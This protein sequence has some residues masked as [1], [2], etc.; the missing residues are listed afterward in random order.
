MAKGI[1]S[2]ATPNP[3]KGKAQN[4]PPP[5]AATKKKKITRQQYKPLDPVNAMV[6]V[7]ALDNPSKKE[8]PSPWISM[9]GVVESV[10]T[11]NPYFYKVKIE[12]N[13]GFQ[14]APFSIVCAEHH[15]EGRLTDYGSAEYEIE[16]I[17]DSRL[18]RHGIDE[19][20]CDKP[21]RATRDFLIKWVGW[22][23]VITW[24]PGPRLQPESI[25][26]YDETLKIKKKQSE[27]VR[28]VLIL[29]LSSVSSAT[30]LTQGNILNEKAKLAF[31]THDCSRWGICERYGPYCQ[32]EFDLELE[33]EG[34]QKMLLLESLAPVHDS[35]FAHVYD[36]VARPV[37][38]NWSEEEEE[39]EESASREGGGPGPGTKALRDEK[40]GA[41]AKAAAVGLKRKAGQAGL[42][43]KNPAESSKKGKDASVPPPLPPGN[44]PI[45]RMLRKDTCGSCSQA[46]K[47]EDGRFVACVICKALVHAG[48]C[49]KLSA[50]QDDE[51]I[52]MKCLGRHCNNCYINLNGQG[53]AC[54][55]CHR[56]FCAQK[57]TGLVRDPGGTVE[58][59]CNTCKNTKISTPEVPHRFS[60][61]EGLSGSDGETE[62]DLGGS[63]I[64]NPI[65][66]PPLIS[67]GLIPPPLEGITSGINLGG[68]E[69][70]AAL[71]P[72][73]LQGLTSVNRRLDFNAEGSPTGLISFL[74]ALPSVNG[75]TPEG[76]DQNQASGNNTTAMVP[77]IASVPL[78]VPSSTTPVVPAAQEPPPVI[79]SLKESAVVGVR[80][81]IT[82]KKGVRFLDSQPQP[83]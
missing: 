43:E 19:I 2:K 35:L 11:E 46:R 7:S 41:A 76:E 75:I 58:T 68:E 3:K 63:Q 28:Q 60:P 59:C 82:K 56:V 18:H 47:P 25:E 45:Q 5:S 39:A 27:S 22:P 38:E 1:P 32:E 29:V 80:Q 17:I 15:L 8:W 55:Q 69:I 83:K 65:P 78:S 30:L 51:V 81:L 26:L 14:K 66:G 72:P 79:L 52:C 64:P 37:V 77:L 70:A 31:I 62:N 34:Y 9:T 61:I 49:S 20:V 4:K 23:G 48:K 53:V 40:K 57:C 67:N 74:E 33:C 54:F 24:E 50:R 6:P 13:L 10:L 36:V 21:C 71:I 16:E 12:G 42:K 44:P 73:P